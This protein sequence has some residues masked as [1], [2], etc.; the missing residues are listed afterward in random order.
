MSWTVCFSG[1]LHVREIAL[2]A[3]CL[4]PN[5][6]LRHPS[7]AWSIM[8]ESRAS[9]FVGNLDKLR[10]MA[11]IYVLQHIQKA[12]LHL[13]ELRKWHL[14][15]YPFSEKQFQN[16]TSWSAHSHNTT[17]STECIVYNRFTTQHMVWFGCATEYHFGRILHLDRHP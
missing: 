13:G 3:L 10:C 14:Y 9:V 11:M 2:M 5:S 7:L 4:Q 16:L 12:M 8:F 1:L 6:S 17:L 15:Q